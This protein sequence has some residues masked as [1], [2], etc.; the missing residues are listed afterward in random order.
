VASPEPLPQAVFM[1]VLRDAWGT[2]IGLPATAW[3]VEIGAFLMRTESELALKSR[4]VVPSRL[5]GA[6]FEF[7]HPSWPE[8]ARDLC[9]RWRALRQSR[10]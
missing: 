1:K 4:R 3:M 2:R 6:G 7:R 8:A 10:F 9:A 5:L